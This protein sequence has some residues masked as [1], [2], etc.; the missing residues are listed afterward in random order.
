[1]GAFCAD[2]FLQIF[3]CPAVVPVANHSLERPFERIL[4]GWAAK[5]IAL[6]ILGSPAAHSVYGRALCFMAQPSPIDRFPARD[7]RM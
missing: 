2:A 7:G 3:H 6:D 5:A 4:R 1:M